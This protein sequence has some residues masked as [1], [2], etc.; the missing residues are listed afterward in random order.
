MLVQIHTVEC[1][2]CEDLGT[3]RAGVGICVPSLV[4]DL[5]GEAGQSCRIWEVRGGAIVPFSLKNG[6]F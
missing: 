1:Q 5:G 6:E 3:N 2:K 4:R